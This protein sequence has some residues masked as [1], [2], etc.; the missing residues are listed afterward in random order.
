MATGIA[1]AAAALGW[2]ATRPASTEGDRAAS[3]GVGAQ[4]AG[5]VEL[6]EGAGAPPAAATVVVH[7]YA[8]DG[9]R[10]PLAVFRHPAGS[11]PIEF[12]LDDR[13]APNPAYRISQAPQLVVGA[14]LGPGDAV[15]AQ[16]G[17]WVAAPQAVALG[18]RGLRL[19]LQP[20]PAAGR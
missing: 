7:A 10:Q 1:V 5:Q 20:T 19:V 2:V 11:W 13:L 18:T 3:T 8:L 4:V 16:P 15:A 12:R 17:D 9:P 14:R 6:G